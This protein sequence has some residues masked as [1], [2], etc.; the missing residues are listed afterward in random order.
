MQHS[1]LITG[2]AGFFGEI[3]IARLLA[4]GT[5]CVSLDLQPGNSRHPALESIQGDVR[6]AALL[7][8]LFATHRFSAVFHCAALLAHDV[9]DREL[10]WQCNVTGTEE[11]ARAALRHHTAR[12]VFISSNCLWTD[13]FDRP[14]TEDDPPRPREVYGK[15]KW[16]AERALTSIAGDRAVILRTPTIIASGRLGL[17]SILF[18]FILEGRRVWVVGAGENR[19]Q[20][21][22]APDLADACVRAAESDATG[23]FN[24]GSDD[25]PSLRETY[26]YVVHRAGTNARVAS[27]P[28]RPTLALMRLAHALGVSPLGPY[29][30]RMIAESFAF[31]TTKIKRTL[32][33]RPT[34]TNGEMLFEA[35]DYYRR[36]LMDITSRSQ[37]SAH[38]QRARPGVIRLLK[39]VS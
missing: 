27:L 6:D 30:Y 39:M 3:L 4:G 22:Y 16:A 2:G 31:D 9:R 20:F 37:V 24:V 19:Y 15:S 14:V 5:G 36:H 28:L 21:I 32:G 33:W 17:L 10:L 34:L 23:V 11:I 18:D 25:V 38:K 26:R 13:P 7:D 29:Q 35:F 8:R 1:A 12:I